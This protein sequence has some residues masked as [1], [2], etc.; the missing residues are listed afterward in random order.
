[1]SEFSTFQNISASLSFILLLIGGTLF[2]CGGVFYLLKKAEIS[3]RL[4]T[5]ACR[6]SVIGFLVGLV[7]TG[8]PDAYLL[9]NAI[10]LLVMIAS[11]LFLKKCVKKTLHDRSVEKMS[12][13]IQFYFWLK[14]DD[15]E[16]KPGIGWK[17]YFWFIVVITVLAFS[18]YLA[19]ESFTIVGSFDFVLSVINAIGFYGFIYHKR[20]FK[21]MFWQYW[22]LVVVIWDVLYGIVYIRCFGGS[23]IPDISLTGDA[24]VL[25]LTI[26]IYLAL[27]KYGCANK[28]MWK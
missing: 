26:P 18:L 10:I 13:E 20:I 11:V 3:R 17:V 24:F 9:Q 2:L 6:C 8:S 15:F 12:Y 28:S 22:L 1:M 14:L 27:F 16:K 19:K 23:Q 25:L 7:G 21:W 4:V 5:W